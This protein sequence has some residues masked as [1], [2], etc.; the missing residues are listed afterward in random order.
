[1]DQVF[2]SPSFVI[3]VVSDT[4]IPDRTRSL[5]PRFLTGLAEN[6]VDLIL[7]AGDISTPNVLAE[8]SEVAPVLAVKGNRDFRF[9]NLPSFLKLEVNGVK[10]FLAH[11]HM[12]FSS[13]WMDKIQHTIKGYRSDRYIQRLTRAMP[14]AAIYIF[15]HSHSSE[16]IWQERKLYFNPGSV[17]VGLPPDFKRTW[18]ILEFN[19]NH[20]DARI[21]PLDE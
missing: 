19:D 14:D 8:L 4:H 9:T 3:G 1:M 12:G 11:G 7:H 6:R 10:I 15:G 2:S 13:Y 20:V 18:G 17:S 21:I 16:I 5:H